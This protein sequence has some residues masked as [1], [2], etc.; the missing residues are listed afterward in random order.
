M[1]ALTFTTVTVMLPETVVVVRAP[2]SMVAGSRVAATLRA[3]PALS[4]PAPTASIRATDPS[5]SVT[6]WVAVF[7]TADFSCAGVHV[8]CF[9]FTMATA[10]ATMG[11]A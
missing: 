3:S 10:P 8:G 6:S 5:V 11:T 7:T 4:L 2:N 1:A 9:C